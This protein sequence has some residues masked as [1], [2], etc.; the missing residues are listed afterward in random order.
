MWNRTML[1]ELR[2]EG[3]VWLHGHHAEDTKEAR[4]LLAAS[5]LVADDDDAIGPVGAAGPTGPTGAASAP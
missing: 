5:A 3:V 2:R 4:A 1:V